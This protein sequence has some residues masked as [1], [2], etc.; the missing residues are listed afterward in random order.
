MLVLRYK[1]SALCCDWSGSSCAS[2]LLRHP[3]PYPER[4]RLPYHSVPLNDSPLNCNGGSMREIRPNMVLCAIS[5]SR[6]F[7]FFHFFKSCIRQVLCR[8]F[9]IQNARSLP[10]FYFYLTSESISAF[11]VFSFRSFPFPCCPQTPF[12]SCTLTFA[13]NTT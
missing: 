13:P 8:T 7:K 6:A 1:S 5:L 4:L 3:N 11:H 2:Q 10:P 9:R 12:P